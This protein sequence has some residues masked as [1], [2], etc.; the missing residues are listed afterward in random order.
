MLAK[1]VKPTKLDR[2]RKARIRQG[3]D[4]ASQL[5]RRLQPVCSL[6]ISRRFRVLA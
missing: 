2:P 6:T 5:R 4:A 1:R 3:S